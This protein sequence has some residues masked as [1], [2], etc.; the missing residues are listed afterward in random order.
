MKFTFLRKEQISKKLFAMKMTTKILALLGA[1]LFWLIIAL[2]FVSSQLNQQKHMLDQ[3]K[4]RLN[5]LERAVK[6]QEIAL[7]ELEASERIG[8]MF[9]ELRYWLMDFTVSWQNDSRDQ[10]EKLEKK[11]DTKINFLS[12][13]YPVQSLILKRLL[14]FLKNTMLRAVDAFVVENR[15]T[16][17]DL[18][19]EGRQYARLIDYEVKLLLEKSSSKEIQAKETMLKAAELVQSTNEHARRAASKMVTASKILG[20]LAVLIASILGALFARWLTQPLRHM[21]SILEKVGKGDLSVMMHTRSQDEVGKMAMALNQVITG[22][23][24]TLQSEHIDWNLIAEQRGKIEE[25]HQREHEQAL[26]LKHKV[27]DMLHVLEFAAKGDLTRQISIQG[28]DVVGQMADQLRLFLNDLANRVAVIGQNANQLAFS[29]KDLSAISRTMADNTKETSTHVDSVVGA[30]QQVKINI[31]SM[32]KDTR[33]LT[34]ILKKVSESSA[35]SAAVA[36]QAVATAENAS[37]IILKLGESSKTVGQVIRFIQSITKQTN[38]LA[39]NATI[40]AASAGSA[41]H[42][43]A[44]VGRSIKD[45]AKETSKAASKI[46]IKIKEIQEEIQNAVFV[47]GEVNEIIGQL[48][49]IQNAVSCMIREEVSAS[50]E[51]EHKIQ[52]AVKGG[53]EMTENIQAVAQ[54][55]K[56]NS[57][58]ASET[59]QAAAQLSQ[60]AHDLKHIVSH[61]Q[62]Q[63]ENA[64]AK[65]HKTPSPALPVKKKTKIKD[66]PVPIGKNLAANCIKTA[67]HR[68]IHGH[69]K[70][71][72]CQPHNQKH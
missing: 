36:S 10:V 30:S 44:V 14:T 27:E 26:E 59:K 67:E 35:T 68:Q 39:L 62:H 6:A 45:L 33:Q 34:N 15:L 61:F 22:I 3:Q 2:L 47:I 8:K 13:I 23:R 40:E 32:A 50:E 41:G 5:E 42:S 49:E 55:V 43:F 64:P 9:A 60:V 31:G 54:E 52:S 25:A 66:H 18:L 53:H 4:E 11:L 12:G 17:N 69:N 24:S 28:T 70:K 46:G 1:S 56:E 58:G 21:A 63:P 57:M 51:I 19:G 71:S 72:D 65:E 37:G 7:E 16:G 29:S 38:L 48:D 20:G